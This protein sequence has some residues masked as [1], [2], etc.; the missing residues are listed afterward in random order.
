MKILESCYISDVRIQN[1]IVLP[2]MAMNLARDG[3]VTREMIEHY[4]KFA[5]NNVG[6]VI[7]EG[8]AVDPR[9][10]DLHGGLAIYSDKFCIGLNELAEEI[11]YNGSA[12]GIQFLHPGGC[13]TPKVEGNEPIAPSSVEYTMFMHGK[14]SF[15]AKARELSREEIRSLVEMFAEAAGRA[16]DCGFDLVEINAAH[17][18]LF[19]QFLSPN[20]NKRSDE[21]GGSFE[22]RIR[23]SLEVLEAVKSVGI[24]VIFR[25]DG[26]FPS[27]GGVS[28]DEILKYAVELEKAGVDCLHVSGG[29]AITPMIVKR[30][31]LLSGAFKIKSAVK[32]PVIG[33]GGISV[34]M[35]VDLIEKGKIDL[36]AL[37]RALLADPELVIKLSEKRIKDIRPCTRC[38]DC[39][40]RLFSSRQ[41]IA[42]CSINPE[43]KIE[44]VEKPKKIVVIGGGVA[45]MEFA[46]IASI[47][48]HKVT[49]IEK[50][51]QLGGNLIPASISSFKSDLRSYLEWLKGQLKNVEVLLKTE[52]T[53]EKIKEIGPE[54]VVIAVGSEH[55]IPNIPGIETSLKAVDVLTGKVKTGKRV[56]ILGGGRIGCETALH[57][58]E[59]GKEVTI[60]EILSDIAL[61][62][63]RNYRFALLRELRNKNVK[64][65]CNFKAEKVAERKIFGSIDGKKV[66][67]EFDSL[68]V[69]TGMKPRKIDIKLEVPTYYIGDCVKPRNVGSAVYEAANLAS[70]I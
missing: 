58:A 4:G 45:G 25:I 19:S 14:K 65:L 54:L 48:G 69:A 9:G 49:I 61:D 47:R 16:K 70:R 15:K 41:F 66:E 68:V 64:W 67:V 6:L 44:K 23:F 13:A 7:V 43:V 12:A 22:N 50:D 37:G 30:G 26:S 57:L 2:A 35:A 38:N 40:D 33:V 29:F 32:V 10:K 18:W 39:I 62:L 51:Q 46:R 59:E 53:S 55:D 27:Y 31:I 28:D 52:A 56:V 17:G 36:V 60:L 34:E 63:E 3:Y 24:P 21:Y 8:A 42:K 20:T 1:R 5:R 11:K